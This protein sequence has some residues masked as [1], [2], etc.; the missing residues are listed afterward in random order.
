M[1][2]RREMRIMMIGKFWI[3]VEKIVMLIVGGFFRIIGKDFTEEKCKTFMQ[4]IKFG[5]VG[6][7][8]TLISYV[9]YLISLKSF[10]EMHILDRYDYIVAQ[11]ISF[12]LSVLW[13][14]YWNNKYVF[15]L[16][17]GES[18]SVFKSLMKTY[19]SYSFTGL[20][21][22]NVLLYFWVEIIGISEYVSPLLNLF[23]S[24]PINFIINKFWAFGK[25]RL[26]EN[27]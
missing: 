17:E 14:F 7:S 5:I 24:V 2:S 23:I 9:I 21:L 15:T 4:F 20:F 18:R 6:V 3:L 8:N 16:S 1:I 12:I 11:V 13:S 19:V 25:E 26:K 10:Q 27:E 22:N